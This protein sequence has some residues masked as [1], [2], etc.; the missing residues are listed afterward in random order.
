MDRDL[1]IRYL[2]RYGLQGIKKIPDA[3]INF[4]LHNTSKTVS[5]LGKFQ[6]DHDSFFYSMANQ[7]DL[8]AEKECI[9]SV[10]KINEEF[11]LGIPPDYQKNTIQKILS[12]YFLKRANEFYAVNEREKAKACMMHINANHLATSEKGLLRKLSFRNTFVPVSVLQFF[13]KSQV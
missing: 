10:S 3:I 1:W 11:V 13:R 12:Y 4:R 7:Y 9:R 5:Q 8:R 2:L 6:I